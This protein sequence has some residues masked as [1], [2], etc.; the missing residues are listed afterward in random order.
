MV[1]NADTFIKDPKIDH[2]I[3][4]VNDELIESLTTFLPESD[5]RLQSKI[6]KMSSA[7]VSQETKFLK[8]KQHGLNVNVACKRTPANQF[9]DLSDNTV[10]RLFLSHLGLTSLANFEEIINLQK[11]NV[12]DQKFNYLQNFN[13]LDKTKERETFQI[14]VIYVEK[15]QNESQIWEN[16][17][18]SMAYHN[19]ISNIG[20][21]IKV[22][23][24]VGFL[25]GLD[26][27]VTGTIAPYYANYECEVIFHV[28][29]MMGV[30]P[31]NTK[32]IHKTRLINNDRVLI[33][34]VEDLDEYRPPTESNYMLN[35]VIHP[36]PSQLYQVRILYK[37]SSANTNVTSGVGINN[38]SND[39]L[40]IFNDTT[41]TSF[42]MIGPLI[43]NV[44]VSE[45]VLPILLRQTC[46]DAAKH[47]S[48][49]N[50]SLTGGSS[51]IH[52]HPFMVRKSLIEDFIQRNKVDVPFHH[53]LASQFSL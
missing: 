17:G 16:T 32:Q 28:S 25:G 2:G 48:K 42:A 18:G 13:V 5:K 53:Y 40:P 7:L 34:W 10:T 29:T 14:G 38:T 47:C 9:D 15:S 20:W 12:P 11:F 45:H 22:S 8:A 30:K 31:A 3:E 6:T 46:I 36:L 41:S 21:M 52:N 1:A 39:L 35:I 23:D 24:H 27:K 37:P 4:E 49:D 50:Q 51:S 43:D 33:S 26:W 19:L 44:V